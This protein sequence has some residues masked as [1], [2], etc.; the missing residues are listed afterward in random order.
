MT[1]VALEEA[2]VAAGCSKQS[3]P[4]KRSCIWKAASGFHFSAPNPDSMYL[5][6]TESLQK[7]LIIIA[8]VNRLKKA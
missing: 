2:L 8:K 3:C 6:P 7:L 5:M 1:V 4:T